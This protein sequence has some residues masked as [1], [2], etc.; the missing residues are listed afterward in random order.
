MVTKAPHRPSAE[1]EKEST[2][3][4]RGRTPNYT[5][6]RIGAA[7]LAALA[8]AGSFH[9]GKDV[10]DRLSGWSQ[11]RLEESQERLQKSY[12]EVAAGLRA[13]AERGEIGFITARPDK[14]EGY[15]SAVKNAHE[16]L[17]PEVEERFIVLEPEISDALDRRSD[18]EHPGI[19]QGLDEND[20]VTVGYLI[21][22]P[23]QYQ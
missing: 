22:D 9:V 7:G 5:L 12:E 1:A 13:R 6:R 19:H 15:Y 18:P 4:N 21:N 16:E 10:V 11:D 8:L 23:G 3:P 17:L 14:G 2:S 20:I